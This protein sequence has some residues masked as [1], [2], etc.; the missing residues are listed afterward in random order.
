MAKRAKK[1]TKKKNK[2]KSFRSFT[3]NTYIK[4]SNLGPFLKSQPD[5]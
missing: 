4:L 3:P 5:T 2:W 1:E